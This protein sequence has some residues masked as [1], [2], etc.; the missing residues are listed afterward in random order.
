MT[1]FDVHVFG[2]RTYAGKIRTTHTVRWQVSGRQLQRTFDTRKLADSFR[3]TLLAA[4]NSGQPFDEGSGLPVTHARGQSGP[5]WLAHAAEFVDTK[6]PRA[7]ARHRRGI[8]E[9]LTTATC[10]LLPPRM[11]TQP[12]RQALRDW[13]FNTA[14]RSSTALALEDLPEWA[15]I[16][17]TINRLLP[18]IDQLAQPVRLNQ[19]VDAVSKNLD[20]GFASPSTTARKRSALYGAL[21]YA[22]EMGHLTANPMDRL[23]SPRS[24]QLEVIDRRVVVNPDQARQ[25]LAAVAEIYPALQAFFGCMYYAALRPAEVR[26]LTIDDL[27]LPADPTMW[28]T[29]LLSGSTQTGGRAWT[30]GGVRDEDRAL[31]HRARR[32]TRRVPAP[33]E[34]VQL[35]HRHVQLF[36]PGVGGRLFVNRVG[37]AGIPVAAPYAS[38]QSMGIVYRVWDRARSQVFNEIQ[39][40]S[41]LAK[42]PYDLR[43]AAVSLW[44]NAGVPATQVAEWAG[45]SV[46]VLLRVYASCVV[47]QDEAAR[48][49]VDAALR[50]STTLGHNP[51]IS[52]LFPQ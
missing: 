16:L 1:S 44:L 50:E 12:V 33:P 15:Q 43:H 30:D 37:R 18:T 23:S 31:K 7:S 17:S 2:I 36:P 49:R 47:G 39:Y 48:Q 32:A 22:V 9:G 28:G 29:L 5:G 42:R 14:A 27:L 13:A 10:G 35:L 52:P 21:T 40:A 4:T 6:W 8:A 26:H 41:V 34:L 45:H 46:N 25:L 11:Q 19:M 51:Q 38:A 3:S 24:R 20:G